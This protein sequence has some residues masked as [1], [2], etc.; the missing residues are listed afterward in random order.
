MDTISLR[1]LV[2]VKRRWGVDRHMNLDP[3][4]RFPLE[5]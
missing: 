1:C 5:T 3:G 4:A 2:D